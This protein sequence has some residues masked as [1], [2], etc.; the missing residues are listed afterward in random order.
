MRKSGIGWFL[1]V[2]LVA[3]LLKVVVLM[4]YRLLHALSRCPHI[5]PVLTVKCNV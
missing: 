3:M 1:G 2:G 5:T 4:A